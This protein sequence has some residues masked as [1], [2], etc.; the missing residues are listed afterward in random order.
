MRYWYVRSFAILILVAELVVLLTYFAI[1]LSKLPLSQLASVD[2]KSFD[3]NFIS[4]LIYNDYTYKVLLSMFVVLQLLTC[5]AFVVVL[6][7]EGAWGYFFMGFEF[8]FLLSAFISWFVLIT[9]YIDENGNLKSEH[10]VGAVVFM[11][12]CG[13][14]FGAMIVKLFCTG[15]VQ[16]VC[17]MVTFGVAVLLFVCSVVTGVVFMVS[18]YDKTVLYGWIYEH[19][20]FVLLI[21]AHLFLF[22]TDMLI[23]VTDNRKCAYAQLPFREVRVDYTN[24]VLRSGEF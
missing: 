2:S 12:A 24:L 13:F 23:S 11:C 8:A 4:G 7:W 3:D 6:N 1:S 10:I 20:S 5:V 16:T 15:K 22:V 19:A 9:I 14:Y 18:F 21:A 17:E